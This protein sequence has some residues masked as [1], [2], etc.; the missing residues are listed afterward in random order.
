MQL[1]RYNKDSRLK[2]T[3]H[4][5]KKRN[6]ILIFLCLV[7]DKKL[8]HFLRLQSSLSYMMETCMLTW[9]FFVK[10]YREGKNMRRKQLIS[11]VSG[12][13]EYMFLLNVRIMNVISSNYHYYKQNSSILWRCTSTLYVKSSAWLHPLYLV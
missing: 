8:N 2:G 10:R 1:H 12:F 11:L 7:N 5:N 9:Y 4:W 6:L 3:L 13:S